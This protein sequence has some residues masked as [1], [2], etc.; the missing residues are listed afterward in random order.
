VAR[1]Q[2]GGRVFLLQGRT[3]L[4]HSSTPTLFGRPNGVR[5]ETE[6]LGRTLSR[7]RGVSESLL[8]VSHGT[9]EARRLL[10]AFSASLTGYF[11]VEEAR[12]YFGAIVSERPDLEERVTALSQAREDLKSSVVS[13]RRLAFLTADGSELARRIDRVVDGFEDHERSEIDLLRS[14][15]VG[16][17]EQAPRR[18][19][20]S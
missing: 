6:A 1:R 14:Y 18:C 13:V 20:A 9:I 12:G 4:F 2:I 19:D 11:N 16:A 17:E 7:L 15:F 10:A 3:V 5:T 8:S